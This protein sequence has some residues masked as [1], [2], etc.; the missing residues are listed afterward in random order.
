[1]FTVIKWRRVLL[2]DEDVIPSLY[3]D[4]VVVQYTPTTG[5]TG[6]PWERLM[7]HLH[8]GKE[9]HIRYDRE[10]FCLTD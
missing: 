7:E 4:E 2:H 6:T 1:M 8:G 10:V 5:H 9:D 3:P